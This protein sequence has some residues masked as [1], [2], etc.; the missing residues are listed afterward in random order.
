M[1]YIVELNTLTATIKF[2][3]DNNLDAMEFLTKA[4]NANIDANEDLIV[5]FSI[6][7][8]MP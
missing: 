4:F 8:E 3:F 2:C 7:E 1:N 5:K 6:Y